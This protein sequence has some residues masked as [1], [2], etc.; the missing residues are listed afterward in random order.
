[1]NMFFARVMVDTEIWIEGW[2]IDIA[3]SQSSMLR[4]KDLTE[5]DREDARMPLFFGRPAPLDSSLI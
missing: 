4:F 1:M 5:G 2:I 3:S